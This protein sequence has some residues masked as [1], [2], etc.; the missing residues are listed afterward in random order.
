[1]TEDFLHYAWRYRRF[2]ISDLY[3]TQGQRIEVL[4]PGEYNRNAGPDFSNARLRIDDVLWAGNV[5]LHLRSSEWYRHSHQEDP[6]Y[7]NVVLHVVLDE[8]L[9]VFNA[10][11]QRIPCL[12]LRK[13][14]DPTAL[15]GYHYLLQQPTWIP[16]QTLW[17][18]VPELTK[19]LWLERLLVERLEAKTDVVQRIFTCNR[20]D[21]EETCYQILAR[22]FGVKVNADPFEELSRHRDNLLQIEALL[23]GQA[24]LLE[25]MYHEKYPRQLQ[26]EARFLRHK[27]D[28][29]PMLGVAWKFLRMRPA[30]FPTVRL[31]QFAALVYRGEHLFSRILAAQ[32]LDEF[33]HLL[34]GRP[35]PY[36]SNHYHFDQ[37][38]RHQSKP[39]GET[40]F[41]LLI[42][43]AVAP[44]LFFYGTYHQDAAY[45]ERAMH[46]LESL[47]P[48]DNHLI[49]GWRQLGCQTLNAGD[50]Q[51]LLHLRSAYCE[52]KRCL[53]CAVGNAILQGACEG[54]SIPERCEPA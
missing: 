51:A 38:T 1:M 40:F 21:W 37:P 14:L 27:Y 30:N 7:A 45:C 2:Q 49:A 31:A 25:G 28:L 11:G 3:S 17:P 15:R 5:E 41:Q 26:Q 50:S 43:N 24:G 22:A 29:K 13:L 48:E 54:M 36:W 42:I 4:H 6:A 10:Q 32:E 53:E 19:T 33:R 44:L 16:C 52:Q 8:D 35:S 20:G 46:L 23:F 18:Q 34:L 9:P 47:P 39:P 12:E